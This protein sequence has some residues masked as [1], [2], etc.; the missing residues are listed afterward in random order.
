MLEAMASGLPVFA[1]EHGGIPEAIAHGNNG[2]LVPEG[3]DAGLALALL[4]YIANPERLAAIA[5]NGAEAIRKKFR[6]T[7][8]TQALEDYYFEAM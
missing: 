4:E 3:D 8:Q 1:S 5:R 2:I 7:A 6:Q